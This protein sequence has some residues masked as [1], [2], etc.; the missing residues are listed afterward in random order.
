MKRDKSCK[1][2][3]LEE[4]PKLGSSRKS[5]GEGSRCLWDPGSKCLLRVFGTSK[6][7]SCTCATPVCTSARGF[8]LPSPQRP[9]ALSPSHLRH[10]LLSGP[11]P[12]HFGL[13]DKCQ[14]KSQHISENYGFGASGFR[15][16]WVHLLLIGS[17]PWWPGLPETCHTSIRIHGLTSE[18][19]AQEA[20]ASPKALRRTLD[21]VHTKAATQQCA[22]KKGL[23]RFLR[24]LCREKVL[25]MVPEG[26]LGIDAFG[27]SIVGKKHFWRG[28]HLW[29]APC[30]SKAPH[31]AYVAILPLGGA[32]ILKIV[33]LPDSSNIANARFGD[34]HCN[35]FLQKKWLQR[36]LFR[37]HCCFSRYG[38]IRL[39]VA[40]SCGNERCRVPRFSQLQS[41]T[42]VYNLSKTGIGRYKSNSEFLTSPVSAVTS[43]E[44]KQELH[45]GRRN[46]L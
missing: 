37:H 22:S 38:D 28:Q 31:Y 15:V 35:L 3:C 42:D 40:I 44:S 43:S 30:W 14:T 9:F 41:R 7:S 46:S 21:W 27:S 13:Q 19:A 18:E 8:S 33:I 20:A 23:T 29:H 45:R 5:L 2:K 25:W 34:L 10:F 12:R 24:V 17:P 32:L 11:S 39:A 16:P 6:T 1:L 26:V 36:V 4:G